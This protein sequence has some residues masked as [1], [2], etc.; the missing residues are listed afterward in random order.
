[1]K[2]ILLPTDFSSNSWNAIKYALSFFKNSRCNFYLYHACNSNTI[3]EKEM[4][5]IPSADVLE[6]SVV[7]ESKERMTDLLKKI[8]QLTYNSKHNFVTLVSFDFLVNGLRKIIDEKKI[9]MIVMGT[10]GASGLKKIILGS[11]TGDTITRV[12][13]PELVIPEDSVYTPIREI[14]FPTD[15]N[16]LY[17]A[18]ILDDL[19]EISE[20]H[21]AAIRVLHVSKKEE[22][23]N[24]EQ[25]ANKQLLEGY[26]KERELSFYRLTNHKLEDAIQCFV[27]SRN[28]NLIAM[29]GKNLNF[30]QQIFFRPAVETISYH[31]EI[32]FLVLHE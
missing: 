26:L 7:A 21:N 16:I 12:K 13:C 1:M 29:V 25:Q 31:T 19:L 28:I 27:E 3:L 4:I 30:F 9:D 8:N 18:R 22:A 2:N 24:E 32:P 6:K 10:K 5:Y 15:F 14:A 11:N 20:I 17:N 23:L